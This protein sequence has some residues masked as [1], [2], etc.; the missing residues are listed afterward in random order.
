MPLQD[1]KSCKG[2]FYL[3][4]AGQLIKSSILVLRACAIA[5]IVFNVMFSVFASP[6]S[7]FWICRMFSSARFARS[8]CVKPCFFRYV[9]TWLFIP[10]I[11]TSQTSSRGSIRDTCACCRIGCIPCLFV[12]AGLYS[13][14]VMLVESFSDNR[15]SRLALDSGF[16]RCDRLACR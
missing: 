10:P 1:L 13:L 12:Q 7:I 16:S 9:F 3:G 6:L 14:S 5:C 4:W 8:V 11:P 15:R 2:F